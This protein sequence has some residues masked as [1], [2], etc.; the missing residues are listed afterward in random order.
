MFYYSSVT[1]WLQYAAAW[2]KVLK[3][4][5][6]TYQWPFVVSKTSTLYLPWYRSRRN[7]AL[8]SFSSGVIAFHLLL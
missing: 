1:N 5:A 4:L 8:C 3:P 6:T 7:D 2:A